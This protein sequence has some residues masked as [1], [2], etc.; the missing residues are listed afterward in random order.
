[1]RLRASPDDASHRLENH[2]AGSGNDSSEP[3]K[4]ERDINK[5]PFFSA[6]PAPV[7]SLNNQTG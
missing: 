6:K 2:E 3:K 7:I 1:V 5:A 4:L